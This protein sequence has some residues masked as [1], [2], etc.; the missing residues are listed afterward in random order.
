[1]WLI[2]AKAKTVAEAGPWPRG[3]GARGEVKEG[4]ATEASIP[5]I[6]VQGHSSPGLTQIM[7]RS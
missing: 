7:N 3:Q 5:N 1:M 2:Q 6:I 4:A